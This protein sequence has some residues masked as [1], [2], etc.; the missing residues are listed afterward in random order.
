MQGLQ[1]KVQ[2][3]TTVEVEERESTVIGGQIPLLSSRL[4]MSPRAAGT[5]ASLSIW[6]LLFFYFAWRGRTLLLVPFGPLDKDKSTLLGA[7]CR[8]LMFLCL[9]RAYD[10][11]DRND[12]F[13]QH[14]NESSLVTR[15]SFHVKCHALL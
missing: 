12:S 10:R 13:L 14:Y 5:T 2:F 8:E 3:G 15:F 11:V 7:L 6:G 4:R 1:G 9:W